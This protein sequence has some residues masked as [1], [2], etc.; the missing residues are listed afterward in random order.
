MSSPRD[1]SEFMTSATL[2]LRLRPDSEQNEIAWA[3]FHRR[4]A[5][6]IAGFAHKLGARGADLEDVVQDVLLSFFGSA[7]K[8][9]YDPGR[10]KFRSFLK[11]CTF[12]QL[13]KNKSRSAKFKGVPIDQ[14]DPQSPEVD[15]EWERIWQD[16]QLRRALDDL[17][18]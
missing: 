7:E 13:L 8:F 18:K 10:G 2:L 16:E 11:T 6:M 17:Q 1:N 12:H 4:Y 3:E 15:T 9:Q 14:V 5:P